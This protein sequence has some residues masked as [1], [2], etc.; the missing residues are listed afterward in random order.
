MNSCACHARD[1]VNTP[2]CLSH[3]PV[4]AQLREAEVDLLHSV[5]RTSQYQKGEVIF[6]EGDRSDALFVVNRGIIKLTK[7]EDNGKEH[8]IRLLFPGDFFG[9]FALLQEKPHYASAI[10]AD[11]TGVCRILRSDFLDILRRDPNTAARFMTALSAQLEEADAWAAVL[12]LLEADRRLAKMLLYFRRKAAPNSEAFMLPVSKKELAGLIGAT[13]ETL[14]RKLRQL[15]D[16]GVLT[17][18]GRQLQIRDAA[19]LRRLAGEA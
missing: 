8:I 3:V 13:P 17:V 15:S 10:A 12:T 6:H 16:D 11:A 19:A 2:S 5:M 9:Q 1:T 18:S 7:L 4:F 14:S